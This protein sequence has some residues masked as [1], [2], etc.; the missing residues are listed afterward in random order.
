MDHEFE[1]AKTPFSSHRRLLIITIV[2]LHL[3][4][5]SAFVTALSEHETF[6]QVARHGR[7]HELLVSV[8]QHCRHGETR[9]SHDNCLIFTKSIAPLFDIPRQVA[10]NVLVDITKAA[11]ECDRD[12]NTCQ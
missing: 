12:R 4:S 3:L 6:D 5:L 1:K 7:D 8:Y 9:R 11:N 2:V 10:A